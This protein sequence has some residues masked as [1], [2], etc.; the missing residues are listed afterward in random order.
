MGVADDGLLPY[1]L[2]SIHIWTLETKCIPLILKD[3]IVFL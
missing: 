1:L 3:A 2:L